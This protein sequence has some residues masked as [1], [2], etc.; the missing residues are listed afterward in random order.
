MAAVFG[1]GLEWWPAAPLALRA[2]A[3]NI[4]GGSGGAPDMT[5][6]VSLVLGGLGFDYAFTSQS[7]GMSHRVVVSYG[8]G[9]VTQAARTEARATEAAREPEPYKPVAPLAPGVK[10]LNVAIADLRAENVSSGDAAVMAD[11]MRSELVK[12]GSFNVIEKQNMEK[13]LSEHAF[14]QTGCT[15][16]ECAVKLGKLLNVQRMAVGSFGKLL[17]S[18][19]LNIRVVNVETGEV[20]F[21]DSVEG[22]TV[23]QLKIGVRDLAGR[24]ARQIR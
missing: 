2:G 19:F 16:E 6:G 9:K 15:T 17:D 3:A 7:L 23:S 14:Q 22:T 1:T 10:K 8:F 24:L 21:G 12:T 4:G 18:Y 11:L 5:A 13:V 20:I